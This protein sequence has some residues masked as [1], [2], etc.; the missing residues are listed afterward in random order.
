MHKEDEELARLLGVDRVVLVDEPAWYSRLSLPFRRSWR[1]EI[2]T[3]LG[4]FLIGFAL[5]VIVRALG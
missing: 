1:R 2:V 3:V 5:G 4:V